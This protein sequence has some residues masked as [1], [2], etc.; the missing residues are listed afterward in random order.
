MFLYVCTHLF[1]CRPVAVYLCVSV[2]KVQI[3][4]PQADELVV[5]LNDKKC[6][7]NNL[8]GLLEVGTN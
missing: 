7:E 6:I 5:K 2:I 3:T 4:T 8:Q 1:I